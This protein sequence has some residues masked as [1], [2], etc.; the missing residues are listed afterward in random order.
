MKACLRRLKPH[1]LNHELLWSLVGLCAMGGVIGWVYFLGP[2]PLQCQFH[3]ITGYPCLTCGSTRALLALARLDVFSAF[4][5]NPLCAIAWAA[6]LLYVPYGLVVSF[7]NLP[8]LRW[9]LS[10]R[11]WFILRFAIPLSA[12]AN[13]A[14][15]IWDK[16]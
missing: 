14:W 7:G 3:A 5:Y 10:N 4:R 12:I 6:W 16:R 8:R 1:E 13:W 2:P 15:L 11:D 9:S